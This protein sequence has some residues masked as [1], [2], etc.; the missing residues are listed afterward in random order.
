[1][2]TKIFLVL[3]IVALGAKTAI[4]SSGPTTAYAQAN[5]CHSATFHRHAGVVIVCQ[6]KQGSSGGFVCKDNTCRNIRRSR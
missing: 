6:P 2:K 5:L 1:M 4:M 3:A